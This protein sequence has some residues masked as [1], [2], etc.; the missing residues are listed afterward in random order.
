MLT[1]DPTIAIPANGSSLVLYV[2]LHVNDGLGITNSIPFYTWFLATLS[3][4][5]HIVYLSPCSKFLSILI[6]CDHP[7]RQIW[8]SSHVYIAD[9]LDE[10]N[11]SNC[12]PA[13]TSFPGKYPEVTMNSLPDITDANLT[14]MYQCLVSCL[15]YLAITTRP[16]IS[17]YAMWLGQHN[18]HP[19]CSHLLMAKHVL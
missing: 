17:Y 2:P 3:K 13:S 11:L 16:N 8:L 4:C 1:L 9:L 15:I 14:L 5:L 12:K 7:N 6:L 19:T 18:A 10:W